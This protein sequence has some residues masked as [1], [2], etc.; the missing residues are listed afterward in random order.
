MPRPGFGAAGPVLARRLGA[1]LPDRRARPARTGGSPWVGAWWAAPPAACRW[2]SVGTPVQLALPGLLSF[3]EGAARAL[4]ARLLGNHAALAGALERVA[5]VTVF[6]L[7]AGWSGVVRLPAVE[8]EEELVLRLLDEE[9]LVVH[10]GY[11]FD[12]P[13]EAYLVVSLLPGEESFREGAARLA[14]A[15]DRPA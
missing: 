12:F 6:P 3:G 2:L 9:D 8:R 7:A 11:F 10:P 15:I 5:G 14:R 13:N 1:P 4:R